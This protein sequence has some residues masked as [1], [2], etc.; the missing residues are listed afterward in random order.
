VRTVKP[1][2]RDAMRPDREKQTELRSPDE[3]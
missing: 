1:S 2:M 3:V